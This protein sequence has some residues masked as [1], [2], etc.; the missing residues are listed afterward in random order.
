M[1]L[2]TASVRTTLVGELRLDWSSSGVLKNKLERVAR[3]EP[4]KKRIGPG[5]TNGAHTNALFSAPGF[6]AKPART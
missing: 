6:R 4:R 3:N 1:L 5:G 2:S